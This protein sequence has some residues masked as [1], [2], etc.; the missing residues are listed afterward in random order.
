MVIYAAVELGDE[1]PGVGDVRHHGIR[2]PA[3]L[4]LERVAA[5][6][7]CHLFLGH[8][9]VQLLGAE[10]RSAAHHTVLVD[11]Q[12]AGCPEADQLVAHPHAEPREVAA[13]SVAPLEVDVLEGRV[14]ARLAQVLL[15]GRQIAAHR[16]VDAVLRNK[17]AAAQP[18]R[19]AQVALPKANGLGVGEGSECVEKQDLRDGHRAIVDRTSRSILN[20]SPPVPS[21]SLP[22]TS[23]P[24]PVSARHCRKFRNPRGL[25]DTHARKFRE[26]SELRYANS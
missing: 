21:R 4:R 9:L 3:D 17:D 25:I 7:E 11:L 2:E 24:V 10:P 20:L 13:R 5:V 8:Q 23:R 15:D 14:L 1:L 12:F 26:R 22:T 16:A 19:F 6:E 18:Q